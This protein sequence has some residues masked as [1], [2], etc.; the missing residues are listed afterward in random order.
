MSISIK[1]SNFR[2]HTQQTLTF[3][4]QGLIRLSGKNGQGKSTIFNAVLF[5]LYGRVKKPYTRG[6]KKTAKVEL[7]AFGLHIVRT[8]RPN[9]V[10]VTYQDQEY[11]GD[12]AEGLIHTVVGMDHSEFM[13]SSYIV[14]LEKNRVSILSMTPAEQLK[15][16]QTLAFGDNQNIE[17]KNQ[18]KVLIRTTLDE[19]IK[20]EGQLNLLN[21]QLQEKIESRG[22][23][24]ERPAEMDEGLDLDILTAQNAEYMEEIG[25]LNSSLD[26][27][28]TVLENLRSQEKLLRSAV[29]K[30]QQ[31][32]VELENLEKTKK[33]LE[34]QKSEDDITALESALEDK[35]T[36]LEEAKRCIAYLNKLETFESLK[37]DFDADT[38]LKLEEITPLVKSDEEMEEMS[39]L[40]TLLES[41]IADYGIL[42]MNVETLTARK[43]EAR[44]TIAECFKEIKASNYTLPSKKPKDVVTSLQEYLREVTTRRSNLAAKRKTKKRFKCPECSKCLALTHKDELI[45]APVHES[46]EFVKGIEEEIEEC[47]RCEQL[48]NGWITIL[49]TETVHLNV[50]IPALPP[51]PSTELASHNKE[52]TKATKIKNDYEALLNRELPSTLMKMLTSLEE[53]RKV[54][55]KGDTVSLK[56]CADSVPE[57]SKRISVLVSSIEAAWKTRTEHS[58]IDKEISARKKILTSSKQSSIEELTKKIRTHEITVTETV[59]K[60]TEYNRLLQSNHELSERIRE[61]E[62]YAALQSSIDAFNDE[63]SLYQTSLNETSDRLEGAYGLEEACKQA[64]LLAIQKTIENINEHARTYLDEFFEE[65]ISVRLES[66]ESKIGVNVEYRGETFTDVEEELSGGERQRCELA[67]ILGINDMVQSKILL[68]DEC[69]N[70]VDGEAGAD[71]LDILRNYAVNKPVIVISHDCVEGLFDEVVEL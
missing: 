50:E 52:M 8:A 2:K 14:Q 30:S 58:R 51:N 3:P 36:R 45:K 38:Q 53:E 19:K 6:I 65:P 54:L 27:I 43:Q 35:Q 56:R 64:E 29:E 17:I 18:V 5:A 26:E 13:V 57:L 15:V 7:T 55:P 16:V 25:K 62:E 34:P 66:G 1:L 40:Q 37:A 11:E 39:S 63:I 33:A 10:V 20:L 31:L 71:I 69:L 67:F 28:N 32:R 61:C 9:R 59:A 44:A 49:E 47:N 23:E 12:A 22:D 24:P 41:Q 70:N 68:L 46:E 21:A 60:L 48:L 42:K 4:E